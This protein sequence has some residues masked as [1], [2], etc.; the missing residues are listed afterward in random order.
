FDSD[1]YADDLPYYVTSAAGPWL[2]IPYALD[3]NDIRFWR[4]SLQVADDFAAYLC[5]AFDHLWEEGA[6]QPR[7]M[8][9]GLHCRI[10]SRPAPALRLDPFSVHAQ[11]RGRVW[12]AT[13]REIAR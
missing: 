13:R 10:A 1:S 5:D 4:G 2:V 12:F 11:R 9:V 7:M 6:T 3:T 8:S